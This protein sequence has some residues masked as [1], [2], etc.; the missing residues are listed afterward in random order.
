MSSN[1]YECILYKY[2]MACYEEQEEYKNYQMINA[3]KSITN[4][5]NMAEMITFRDE[6]GTRSDLN[7]SYLYTMSELTY[8]NE[9]LFELYKMHEWILDHNDINEDSI[10]RIRSYMLLKS[11]KIIKNIVHDIKSATDQLIAI[12]SLQSHT[13]KYID[14]IGQLFRCREDEKDFFN[15]YTESINFLKQLNDMDNSF[16]HHITND[17]KKC[18]DS[19]KP[20]ITVF[21]CKNYSKGYG[22][23]KRDKVIEKPMD[24]FIIEFNV[25][26]YAT[27]VL[28][29]KLSKPFES[30]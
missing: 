7:A 12:A 11:S 23:D 28:L 9:I 30:D 20:V 17:I 3:K 15:N 27:N 22:A 6:N 24:E 4:G 19:E 2:A 8:T 29:K 18:F 25:F 21:Y 14:S 13:N 5:V 26:L 1:D 10:I 16:K